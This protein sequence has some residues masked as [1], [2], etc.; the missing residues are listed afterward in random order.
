MLTIGVAL[1]FFFFNLFYILYYC[2][3]FDS[4]VPLRRVVN[5]TGRCWVDLKKRNYKCS[6]HQLVDERFMKLTPLN[7]D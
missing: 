7:W 4:H 1:K 6:Q 3:F 2:V 5:R